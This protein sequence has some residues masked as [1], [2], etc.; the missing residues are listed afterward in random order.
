MVAKSLLNIGCEGRVGVIELARPEKFNCLSIDLFK[1]LGSALDVFEQ[2]DDIAALVICGQGKNFCTG[3]QLD[4]VELIR[5]DESRLREFMELGHHVLDRLENSRL[6]VFA[7]I[8]GLCL[9]GGLEL[10]LA[11]DIAFAGRSARLGDQHGQ[12]GLVPGWGGSQRLPKVVGQRRAL[13]LFL[14]VRWLDSKDALEWGLLNYVVDDGGAR[15]AALAYAQKIGTRS[16]AGMALMK[17]LA[18]FADRNAVSVGKK[19]EIDIAVSVLMSA[20]VT[21]GLAAFKEKRKPN[22][23]QDVTK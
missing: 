2:S 12:F 10:M 5:A 1:E 6:P 23:G 13:D 17:Q 18:R 16:A 11:C 20:D 3:A 15:A 4:E 21:E 7:A 14:S 8:E 19:A 9:A 22:F